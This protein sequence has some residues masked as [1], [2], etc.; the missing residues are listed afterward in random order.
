MTTG[1]PPLRPVEQRNL[2]DEVADALRDSIR[3]GALPP[4][5][6][7]IE[8]ELAEQ[9]GVSRIPV[10]EA[11]QRL[12]EEGIVR[13]IPHRGAFVYSP[14]GDE[15]EQISSL[16]VVMERFVVERVIERW[17]P[18]YET[19]LRSIVREMRAAAA[20]RDMQQVY[21]FDYEFHRTLWEVAEHD[22]L[23]EVISGLRVRISRFLY[24]ATSALTP[25]ELELHISSHDHMIDVLKSR[26]VAAA[27]V[28]ITR[29][30][31]G[32]KNRIVNYFNLSQAAGDPI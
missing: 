1:S 4:G 27:H 6:R 3:S 26:E 18:A 25:D 10:R 31:L 15:I 14:S 9:L 5:I 22:L 23:L 32:A 30:I 24:E 17:Q 11:I 16:R 20:R 13:K 8:R 21:A 19:Q 29:H 2:S 12:A 28:E 7:L